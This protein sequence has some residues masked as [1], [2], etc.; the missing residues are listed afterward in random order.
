MDALNKLNQL[1]QKLKGDCPDDIKEACDLANNLTDCRKADADTLWPVIWQKPL[2]ANTRVRTGENWVAALSPYMGCA[3]QDWGTK[4]D[5][6][7][8][9]K[10]GI[11]RANAAYTA[12]DN[13]T[14]TIKDDTGIAFARLYSIQG[15][16]CALRIRAG[17]SKKPMTDLADAPLTNLVPQLQKEFGEGWGPVTILHLLT[18]LGLAVKPDRHLVRTC[19]FL[20]LV[21][22]LQAGDIPNLA[23]TIQICNAVAELCEEKFGNRDPRNIRYMDKILMEISRR[24]LLPPD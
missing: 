21:N 13:Q 4:A 8:L 2:F 10:T 11:G 19:V 18:D 22:G 12:V 16:A 20:D 14:S 1:E 15:A 5:S 3:W 17:N 24:G 23:T 7:R 9:K 6:F